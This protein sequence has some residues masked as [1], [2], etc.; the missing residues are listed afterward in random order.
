MGRLCPNIDRR[1]QCHCV[2]CSKHQRKQKILSCLRPV[3]IPSQPLHGFLLSSVFKINITKIKYPFHFILSSFIFNSLCFLTHR[4]IQRVRQTVLYCQ[5]SGDFRPLLL[6]RI[7][8]DNLYNLY[9]QR[10]RG[11][12]NRCM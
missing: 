7:C 1:T 11:F 4:T 9:N 12:H 6:S 8:Q 5:C 2:E 10:K 3:Y